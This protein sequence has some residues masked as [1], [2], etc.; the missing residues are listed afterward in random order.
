MNKATLIKT[1]FNWGLLRD[2]EVQAI[3]IKAE[4]WQCPSRQAAR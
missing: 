4:T 3:T 1:T 2:S